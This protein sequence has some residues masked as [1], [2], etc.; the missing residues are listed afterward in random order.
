[1]RR[2]KPSKERLNGHLR[3]ALW[4]VYE[5]CCAYTGERITGP[6]H[7]VID[8]VLPERLADDAD[9]RQRALAAFGLPS[10]FQTRGN[11]GNLVPTT[12][13]FNNLK[14]DKTRPDE[15]VRRYAQ[16][17]AR[18]RPYEDRQNA[19]TW[20]AQALIAHGLV[21]AQQN[22]AASFVTPSF[23]ALASIS[24]VTFQSYLTWPETRSSCSRV[25]RSGTR[26]S[27]SVIKAF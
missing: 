20:S 22:R 11:L 27:R 15:I 18:H 13:A 8:H 12:Q 10:D 4:Y 16:P 5:K 17:Y 26:A 2:A 1:M 25:S 23:L 9:E 3:V 6:E 7:V 19:R 24:I 21:L 14:L